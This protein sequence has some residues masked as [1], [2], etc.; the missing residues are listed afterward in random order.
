MYGTGIDFFKLLFFSVGVDYDWRIKS[1]ICLA[2]IDFY[3]SIEHRK[4]SIINVI[5]AVQGK[6]CFVLILRPVCTSVLAACL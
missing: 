5:L 6:L 1:Y 2:V 3:L 4:E